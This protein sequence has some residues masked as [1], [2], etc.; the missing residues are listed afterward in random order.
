MERSSIAEVFRRG[1][2]LY[3]SRVALISDGTEHSYRDVDDDSSRLAN[4]L[5]A[6]GAQPGDRIATLMY[7]GVQHVTVF[8]AAAKAG[9][10]VVPVNRR[11]S[12]V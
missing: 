12:P 1:A 2:E 6:T 9:L 8:V 7:N 5:L 10:V 4:A 3:G 11:L